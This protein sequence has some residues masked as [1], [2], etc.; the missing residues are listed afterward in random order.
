MDPGDNFWD[1]FPSLSWE[2]GQKI[3]SNINHKKLLELGLHYDYPRRGCLRAAVADIRDGASIGLRDDSRIASRSTNAPSA[4][5]HGDRVTDALAAWVEDGLAIGPYKNEDIPFVVYRISGLMTKEKPN[6]SVRI[7]VNLS[8]GD[9]ISV[10]EG[11]ECPELDTLMSSTTEWIRIL[12]KIGKGGR[13]CKLDWSSAYK[14]MMVKKDDVGMQGFT[15]MGR[16]FFELGL[17]FGAKSSAGLF[18]RLAKIVVHISAMRACL[19]LEWKIQHLDDVCGASPV[20]NHAVDR[21]YLS[22]QRTA[23][24]LGV[25]L[26]S[27]E[28]PEKCFAPRTE[29][30]VLGTNYNTE[31]MTWSIKEDKMAVILNLIRTALEL[32]E[33]TVREVK[34][35]C[36]KLLP[37]RDLIPGAK[38]HMAHMIML[39]GGL[40]RRDE[41]DELV[42]LGDWVC[43]DL[44][45]FRVTLPAYSGRARLVDPDEGPDLYRAVHCYSDAAGGSADSVGRGVGAILLPPGTWSVILWG[46]EINQGWSAY[47]GKSLACKLSA[48]ELLGPLLGLVIGGNKLTG[49]QLVGWVDNQGSVVMHQKGWSSK[50]DL[51]NTL[52]VAIHQVSVAL[53]CRV[54][55]KKIARCSSPG[56]IGADAISKMDMK[57]FRENVPEAEVGPTMVPSALLHWVEHPRPNRFLGHRMLME[58]KNKM[59]LLGY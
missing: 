6:G 25:E 41:L 33:Q 36:G 39:S 44:E 28:D 18:D 22:Y 24:E 58:M 20:G 3:R 11:I 16:T 13:F 31:D 49:R 34:R 57:R 52:L 54:F 46:K 26:A 10:N 45:Y 1:Q 9:P 5:E 37:M 27:E 55:L 15:W 51:C 17:V 48:W 23:K 21:F 40:N 59:S 19:P 12:W 47:D 43:S 35:I 38:F 8:K 7:I 2:D 14:Q 50:C 53:D 56:A 29:G 4:I 42:H 30:V 32:R